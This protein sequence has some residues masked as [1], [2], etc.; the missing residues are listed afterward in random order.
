[1]YKFCYLALYEI[2]IRVW[3]FV[4]FKLKSLIKKRKLENISITFSLFFDS[5]LFV[6]IFCWLFLWRGVI[7]FCTIEIINF[8]TFPPDKNNN[9]YFTLMYYRFQK[10]WQ[11]ENVCVVLVKMNKK[12]VWI[13]HTWKTEKK[14]ILWPLRI[15]QSQTSL[16]ILIWKDRKN[17]FR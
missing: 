6:S 13:F 7:I 2:W 10:S 15:N 8:A 12:T 16:A 14:D 4:Q 11:T 5:N 9:I 1:M 17:N 3:I